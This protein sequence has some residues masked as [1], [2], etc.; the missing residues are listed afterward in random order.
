[1][2]LDSS[3]IKFGPYEGARRMSG[4]YYQVMYSKKGK[5]LGQDSAHAIVRCSSYSGSDVLR[6]RSV[7]IVPINAI[8]A[9][10]SAMYVRVTYVLKET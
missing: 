5:E 8:A 10:M 9:M 4:D 6:L 1:M 2:R 7:R 3:R